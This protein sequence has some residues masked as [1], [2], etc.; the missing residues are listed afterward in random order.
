MDLVDTAY[1]FG[2][3]TPAGAA[4][5]KCYAV[6]TKLSTY[7]P[8]IASILAKKRR[9]REA[10]EAATFH[11]TPI[12]K[13]KAP[14]ACPRVG[15]RRAPTK[16]EI[17][18]HRLDTLPHRKRADVIQEELKRDGQKSMGFPLSSS[19]L[20]SRE[21]EKDRLADIMT[22]GEELPKIRKLTGPQLVRYHKM[23]P[24]AELRYRFQS[25]KEEALTLRSQLTDLRKSSPFSASGSPLSTPGVDTTVVSAF[26]SRDSVNGLTPLQSAGTSI[27]EASDASPTA[28]RSL[29][30]SFSVSSSSPESPYMRHGRLLKDTRGNTV[31]DQ[32]QQERNLVQSLRAVVHEMED[33]DA[34]LRASTL[35]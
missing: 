34:Q 3:G 19:K 17:A 18:R 23:D 24:E 7:D 28:G 35:S 6:P 4:L 11:P 14:I 33:V 31:L 1:V 13:S 15:C 32:Q 26:A 5:Y 16:E 27:V 25:L 22:Y 2:R 29:N 10:R 12:P 20:P 8:Q 9:E 30:G 21:N